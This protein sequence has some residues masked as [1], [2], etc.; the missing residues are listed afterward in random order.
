MFSDATH[1]YRK[2]IFICSYC[3]LC[4]NQKKLEIIKFDIPTFSKILKAGSLVKYDELKEKS[5]S[6]ASGYFLKRI[7]WRPDRIIPKK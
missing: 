4:Y 7:T 1:G 6:A 2:I 3:N 5:F